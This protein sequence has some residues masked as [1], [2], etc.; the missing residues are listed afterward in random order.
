[1]KLYL[2]SK[3]NIPLNKS[4]LRS[5][6]RLGSGRGLGNNL[7]IAFFIAKYEEWSGVEWRDA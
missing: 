1:M 7:I 2:V 4:A 5:G 6:L 3:L